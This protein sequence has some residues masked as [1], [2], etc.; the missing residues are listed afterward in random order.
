MFYSVT[1]KSDSLVSGLL[2][3][4]VANIVFVL[5]KTVMKNHKLY[6]YVKLL[7]FYVSNEVYVMILIS[8]WGNDK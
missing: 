2:S 1:L 8:H 6:F 7:Y 3:V 5:W 4:F